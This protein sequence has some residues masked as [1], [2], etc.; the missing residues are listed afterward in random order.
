M[1]G[2]DLCLEVIFRSGAVGGEPTRGDVL[3]QE[4]IFLVP[5]IAEPLVKILLIIEGYIGYGEATP[6][7]VD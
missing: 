5:S 1:L 2:L 4:C 7:K 3:F 6:I